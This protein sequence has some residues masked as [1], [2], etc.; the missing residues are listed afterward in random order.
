MPFRSRETLEHWLAEFHDARGAGDLIRVIVQDGTEGADTGL[1]V[2]PLQNA[3]VSVFM[4]PIDIGDARWRITIEPQPDTTILSSH[5]LHGMAVELQVAAELC[6]FL[7][8][9]SFGHEESDREES[10]P[11]A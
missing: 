5:Q 8:A 7:E 11:E 10:D 6:A 3:T 2:V 9:K 4:E 1:V